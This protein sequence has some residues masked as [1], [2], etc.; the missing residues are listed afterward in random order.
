MR[1][2]PTPLAGVLVAESKIRTDPRGSF[3]RFFCADELGASLSGRRI[4]QINHT[5][6]IQR[7][8]IRGIHYQRP[9]FGEMK[10]IRCLRGLVWDVVVDLRQASPTFLRWYAIELSP[11]NARMVIVPEGCAHGFQVLSPGSEL[12]YLHTEVYAP[13]A[14]AGAAW[15]DPRVNIAWPLP[16]PERDGLSER[17]RRLPRLAADFSGIRP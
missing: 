10:F 4:V 7:G 2:S 3:A 17:D 15:D 9:P 1:L 16:L 8:T 13:Q 14:E 12:L 5:R 11:D 6:T